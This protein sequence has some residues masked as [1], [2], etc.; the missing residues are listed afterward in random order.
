MH[1][2]IW[3]WSG[4]GSNKQTDK[5]PDGRTAPASP[6]RKVEAQNL[7]VRTHL[8]PLVLRHSKDEPTVG[9][10]ETVRSW[11]AAWLDQRRVQPS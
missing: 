1:A 3:A 11:A 9:G 10:D 8:S 2:G 6:D 4:W 7:K 5:E